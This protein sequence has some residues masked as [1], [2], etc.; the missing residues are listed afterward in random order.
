[1]RGLNSGGSGK[2]PPSDASYTFN[3][4]LQSLMREKAFFAAEQAAISATP[5]CQWDRNAKSS[6]GMELV[7][8]A[9]SGSDKFKGRSPLVKSSSPAIR[10]NHIPDGKKTN[11]AERTTTAEA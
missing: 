7:Q 5:G 1:M 9:A 2:K 4:I 6:Q 11:A 8:P 10:S 3:S